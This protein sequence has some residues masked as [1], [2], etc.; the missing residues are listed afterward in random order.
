MPRFMVRID[1]TD[2][3]SESMRICLP[4]RT[5]IWRC[6]GFISYL[7]EKFPFDSVE[8]AHVA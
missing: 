7:W 2:D 4:A 8:I 3:D 5:G 1:P 6:F